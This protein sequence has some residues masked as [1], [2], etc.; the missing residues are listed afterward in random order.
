MVSCEAGDSGATCQCEIHFFSAG[1][2]MELTFT[3]PRG[4]V[5]GTY[6]FS[7]SEM[8]KLARRIDEA[9]RE[10]PDER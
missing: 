9:L 4:G 2:Q 3:G 1:R 6:V 5:T 8:K 10:S 7:R